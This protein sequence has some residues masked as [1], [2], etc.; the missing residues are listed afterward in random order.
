MSKP[1]IDISAAKKFIEQNLALVPTTEIQ[2]LIGQSITTVNEPSGNEVI[3]HAGVLNKVYPSFHPRV[4]RR[5]YLKDAVRTFYSKGW[6][7]WKQTQEE[8][9]STDISL[10]R[11]IVCDEKYYSVHIGALHHTENCNYCGIL[12][13]HDW[14]QEYS[15]YGLKHEAMRWMPGKGEAQKALRKYPKQLE[16]FFGAETVGKLRKDFI[17]D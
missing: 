16:A 8:K 11:A 17:R 3:L 7:G 13:A 1:T 10:I 5:V 2:D 4:I 6:T 12:D 15:H 14:I 9:E